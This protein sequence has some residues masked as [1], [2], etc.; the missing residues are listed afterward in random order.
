MLPYLVAALH[1]LSTR[2]VQ[3][4]LQSMNSLETDHPDVYRKFKAGFHVV[5][6]SNRLWAGL[7]TDPVREQVLMRSLTTSGGLTRGFGC[8]LCHR[9]QS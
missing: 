5:R 3:L 2:S 8:S 6:R 1:N 4:Y 9:V 7:S